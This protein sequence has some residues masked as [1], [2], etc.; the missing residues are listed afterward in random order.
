[1]AEDTGT[2]FRRP[3][4]DL[5][6]QRFGRLVVSGPQDRV[7]N[8]FVGWRCRCDCGNE[9][10]V[11]TGELQRK[12]DSRRHGVRS[13]GCLQPESA[14]ATHTKHGLHRSPEYQAWS[15]MRQRCYNPNDGEF[16]RYGARGITVCDEWRESFEA[17]YAHVGPRPSPD[18]SI[19]RI[20]TDG[21]YVPG[22][23]RWS[24]RK[25]QQRNR[26][27]TTFI[28]FRGERMPLTKAAEIAGVNRSTAR[29]RHRRGR[30]IEF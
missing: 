21:H 17:F 1:M 13:C 24:T 19:D 29:A 30:P 4:K 6:G 16:K 23:V 27:N 25:E 3:N 22:N 5:T 26:R 28:E 10:T 11:T 20:A 12:Q 8:R 2:R 7:G 9:T 18:H 15:D 14:I